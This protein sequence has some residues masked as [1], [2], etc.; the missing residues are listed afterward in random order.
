MIR[1]FAE[2]VVNRVSPSRRAERKQAASIEDQQRKLRDELARSL[3]AQ[4]TRIN[5]H[6]VAVEAMIDDYW[7][8][9]VTGE[10]RTDGQTQQLGDV[11]LYNPGISYH[12]DNPLEAPFSTHDV[13]PQVGEPYRVFTFDEGKTER[14][15]WSELGDAFAIGVNQ[16]R[17]MY[18]AYFSPADPK[19]LESFI[20]SRKVP[21]EVVKHT[22][23][24]EYAR[25]VD[26]MLDRIDGKA[27]SPFVIFRSPA[28]GF[29]V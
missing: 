24:A 21:S 16:R 5:G 13:I 8:T 11:A 3:L 29:K 26:V 18:N 15:N 1:N 10:L 7:T 9:Y 17:N 25:S 2:A 28:F 14:K 12:R 19:N 27:P 4:G 20:A 6:T 23:E 22:L